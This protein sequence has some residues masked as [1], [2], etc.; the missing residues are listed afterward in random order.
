MTLLVK[1]WSK[2][3][4][5][6]I[7]TIFD[8][9]LL[10]LKTSSPWYI[11]YTPFQCHFLTSGSYTWLPQ[12][13]KIILNQAPSFGN[14]LRLAF[15]LAKQFCVLVFPKFDFDRIGL[16]SQSEVW[17]FRHD[18]LNYDYWPFI[19]FTASLQE[20]H[21]TNFKI[22]LLVIS[23][24]SELELTQK[25]LFP[26]CPTLIWYVLDSFPPLLTEDFWPFNKSKWW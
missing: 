20:N 9:Q 6:K 8:K 17:H 4:D 14:R 13:D 11:S 1:L 2:Q 23:F 21:T 26:P 19:S 3:V 16:I 25:F 22:L 24:L 10:K 5:L 7:I 18:L 12:D 15:Q